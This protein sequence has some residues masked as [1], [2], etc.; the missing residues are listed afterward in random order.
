LTLHPK[1]QQLAIQAARQY[2]QTETFAKQYAIRSGIEGTIGLATDKLGM[3]RSRYR[4]PAKTH[5][6]HI[7]TAA[8]I[9]IKRI[10]DWLSGNPRSQARIS[11][12]AALAT[13]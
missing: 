8:A 9:N 7:L 5:L 2:Q 10:L 12:F 1:N 6:H 11:H 3:R 4:G 13:L